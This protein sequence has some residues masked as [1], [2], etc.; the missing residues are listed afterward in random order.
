MERGGHL[1]LRVGAKA[2]AVLAQDQG[3]LAGAECLHAL[4]VEVREALREEKTIG[5]QNNWREKERHL[6]LQFVEFSQ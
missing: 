4:A 2:K 3:K 5:V 1:G 6:S